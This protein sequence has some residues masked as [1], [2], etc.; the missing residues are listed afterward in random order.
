VP[1]KYEHFI[2]IY[3]DSVADIKRDQIKKRI[4]RWQAMAME[5]GLELSVMEINESAEAGPA[6]AKPAVAK[7]AK[8]KAAVSKAA[9]ARAGPKRPRAR[10]NP[11]LDGTNG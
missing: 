4:S 11:L 2:G 6:E 9:K 8:A 1:S 7:A 10:D 5:I 3:K